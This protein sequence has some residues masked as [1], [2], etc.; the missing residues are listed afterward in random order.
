M[1]MNG[2]KITTKEFCRLPLAN[3]RAIRLEKFAKIY[4]NDQIHFLSSRIKSSDAT[5]VRSS[6]KAGM[7]SLTNF[8]YQPAGASKP[9]ALARSC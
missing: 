4:R 9:S 5:Q 7:N 6:Q 3:S 2:H 1:S 8:Q